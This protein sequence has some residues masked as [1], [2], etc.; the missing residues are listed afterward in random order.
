MAKQLSAGIQSRIKFFSDPG[1]TCKRCGEGNDFEKRFCKKCGRKNVAHERLQKSIKRASLDRTTWHCPSCTFINRECDRFCEICNT[2]RS[3]LV[4]KDTPKSARSDIMFDDS[5]KCN[6]IAPGMMDNFN[7]NEPVRMRCYDQ[8]KEEEERKSRLGRFFAFI[9]GS[10]DK[11]HEEKD[12][13]SNENKKKSKGGVI[14]NSKLFQFFVGDNSKSS[15][16]VKTKKDIKETK[17]EEEARQSV[18]YLDVISEDSDSETEHSG[19]TQQ[20]YISEW[21]QKKLDVKQPD[22]KTVEK[23]PEGINLVVKVPDKKREEK[24]QRGTDFVVKVPDKKV[25]EKKPGGSDLVVKIIDRIE[26]RQKPGGLEQWEPRK[27]LPSPRRKEGIGIEDKK[28]LFENRLGDKQ[29]VPLAINA[30]K[31]KDDEKSNVPNK[32]QNIKE[33][34][35]KKDKD[36][37]K[38]QETS[39]N[40]VKPIFLRQKDKE[41]FKLDKK[42]KDTSDADRKKERWACK[43]CSYLNDTLAQRCRMCDKQRTKIEANRPSK[44]MKRRML[45]SRRSLR[46]ADLQ[47]EEEKEAHQKWVN[48]TYY[49]RENGSMFVDEQFPPNVSS[50]YT[51]PRVTSNN[52]T[53]LRCHDIRTEDN[54]EEKDDWAVYR[55]NPLADDIGQGR[56]GN[57]WFLSALAVLAERKELLEKIILTR[58]F[59]KEG[60]YHVRLC[61]D[62]RWKIVL[63]DDFFPCD[64]YNRLLYSKSKR[65]QLWV[66][67]IEKAAAKL[68]GCYEALVS[69]R[70][71]EAL[72][73]LT[74]EPCERIQLQEQE[75]DDV[76]IDEKKI[77]TKLVK[78]RQ[79]KFLMGTS[80]GTLNMKSS[81]LQHYETLGL[82]PNH[83]Y[84]LLDVQ[85]AAGNRLVKIRNPWGTVSW[86][87]NWSDHSSKWSQISERTKKG[88]QL[89]GNDKGIFWMC[90]PDFMRYFDSVEVCKARPNWNELRIKGS[91]PPHADQPWKF[92][93]LNIFNKTKMDLCLFQRTVRGEGLAKEPFVDMMVVVLANSK[94]QDK[95]LSKV[96]CNSRRAAKP[97]TGCE[98]ELGPGTYTVACLAF[99][100]WQTGVPM[101][102]S[103][104]MATIEALN[105]DFVLTIHSSGSVQSDEFDTCSPTCKFNLADVI[106]LLAIEK[107]TKQ[108]LSPGLNMYALWWYG[109]IFVVENTTS[110]QYGQVKCD[111]S[112]SSY[113]ISTRGS[114]MTMDCVPPKH[115]QVIQVL[116]PLEPV[117]GWSTNRSMQY[118]MSPTPG[119]YRE[120]RAPNEVLHVPDIT[121]DVAGLHSPQQ[122]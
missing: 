71:I 67:L 20:T 68:H 87:G 72:A 32:R 111:T 38:T 119:L 47:K 103:L 5:A 7:D 40:A 19:K 9:T 110:D 91:F 6:T 120:W 82:I 112:S 52:P 105:K 42:L 33:R 4:N 77:W 70:A 76:E 26:E 31:E 84:S 43:S 36:D 97:F 35:V 15:D 85:D 93:T 66:P 83:A 109:A 98:V 113:L 58:Q 121:T 39:G 59:C 25:E 62:G 21:K 88:I 23:K 65:K 60:A 78:A 3:D 57:C 2:V 41:D 61:K 69:G 101:S 55:S 75:D 46:I 100:H 108:E 64:Q 45:R 115:R 118:L 81:D 10:S 79:S 114:F 44:L 96:V 86:K 24:K 29:P 92:V 94:S 12:C 16:K 56:L 34:Y 74:G 18:F 99:K 37:R 48:I 13:N 107:G 11:I 8:G 17:T 27:V 28:R 49:C 73:L 106:I 51:R 80:C 89:D 122:Y 104:R 1:W 14:R 117:T 90:L 54:T 22:K 95:V 116:T 50:L 53:W 30:R 102:S 63:I